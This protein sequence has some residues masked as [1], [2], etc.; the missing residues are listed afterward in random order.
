M[1]ETKSKNGFAGGLRQ[2]VAVTLILLY[3]VPSLRLQLQY[4]L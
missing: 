4:V 3:E 1:N 2:A